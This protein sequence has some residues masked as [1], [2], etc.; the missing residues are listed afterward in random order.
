MFIPYSD[1]CCTPTMYWG[2]VENK[3]CSK[4]LSLSELAFCHTPI[5]LTTEV[6]L[7]SFKHGACLLSYSS[8]LG[9][10]SSKQSQYF[11]VSQIFPQKVKKKRQP[12]ILLFF[13][14]LKCFTQIYLLAVKS[15]DRHSCIVSVML[16]YFHCILDI[17]TFDPTCV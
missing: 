12:G 4:V 5:R 3:T 1:I 10:F 13:I 15:G 7:K 11:Q 16:A 8:T 9:M 14:N 17:F 2:R 6:L